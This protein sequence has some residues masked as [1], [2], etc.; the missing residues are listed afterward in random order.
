[1]GLFFFY[2][3]HAMAAKARTDLLPMRKTFRKQPI[4]QQVVRQSWILIGVKHGATVGRFWM[5]DESVDEMESGST[6]FYATFVGT[7]E[8]VFDAGLGEWRERGGVL[9]PSGG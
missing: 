6:S 2:A 1:M 3:E 9:L 5:V 4:L 7:Y 8:I